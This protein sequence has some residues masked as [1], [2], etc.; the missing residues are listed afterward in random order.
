MGVAGRQRPLLFAGLASGFVPMN[1]SELRLEL[2]AENLAAARAAIGCVPLH[3]SAIDTMAGVIALAGQSGSGKSTLTA[4]AVLAGYGYVADEI[5]SVSPSDLSVRSFHR[6]IG[7]RRGGAEAIGIPYPDAPDGR[8][9]SIYP[10]AVGGSGVLS[11]G[12]RLAGIVIVDRLGEGGPSLADVD[13]PQALVELSQHTVIPDDRLET[14][15]GQLDS[16]VRSVPV[17][18]MTYC[19]TEESLSLLEQLVGRWST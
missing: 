7:L 19:T 3:A 16:I 1:G 14:A 11:S 15:F 13:G 18:R 6:P 8:Y 4:A 12:G 10:W 2:E 9:D 17:V 5:T